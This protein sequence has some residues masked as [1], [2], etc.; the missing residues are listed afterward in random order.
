MKSVK[1]PTANSETVPFFKG[2][3]VLVGNHDLDVVLFHVLK[4]TAHC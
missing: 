3:R 4:V 1:N 2:H